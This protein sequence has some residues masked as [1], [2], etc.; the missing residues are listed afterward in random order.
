M[1]NAT[2]FTKVY[3]L[4]YKNYVRFCFTK[5]QKETNSFTQHHSTIFFCSACQRTLDRFASL[6]NRGEEELVTAYELHSIAA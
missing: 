6:T 2:Q 1:N 5:E 4:K 3:L